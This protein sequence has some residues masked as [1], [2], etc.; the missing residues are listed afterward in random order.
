MQI[1]HANAL[2]G[3]K[4]TRVMKCDQIPKDKQEEDGNCTILVAKVKLT[5][6]CKFIET[7][8]VVGSTGC[9][10]VNSINFSIALKNYCY[11]MHFF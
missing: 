3:E 8:R 4:Y 5:N 1:D 7:A 6:V 11:K 2:T 9:F 10:C